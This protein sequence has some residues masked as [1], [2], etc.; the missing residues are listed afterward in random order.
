VTSTST[1]SNY[2]LR[3][4]G[5][6]GVIY[7]TSIEQRPIKLDLVGTPNKIEPNMKR[8]SND[9]YDLVLSI[10]SVKKLSEKFW[11]L[12]ANT[13]FGA[14]MLED[15]KK[16]QAIV[17]DM[18]EMNDKKSELSCKLQVRRNDNSIEITP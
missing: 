2:P 1:S 8:S 17:K 7:N 9:S 4:Q 3:S 14:K 6:I 18:K 12:E 11:K 10:N 15:A 5:A 13:P 16:E